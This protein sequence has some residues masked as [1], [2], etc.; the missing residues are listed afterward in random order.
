[1]TGKRPPRSEKQEYQGVRRVKGLGWMGKV[2]VWRARNVIS[3]LVVEAA[4]PRRL[5]HVDICS[6]QD[7]VASLGT[8][9]PGNW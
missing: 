6:F 5:Y 9:R 4:R 3:L 7:L 2:L 8:V 1:M